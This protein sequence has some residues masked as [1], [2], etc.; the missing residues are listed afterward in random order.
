MIYIGLNDQ[1]HVIL[2]HFRVGEMLGPSRFGVVKAGD[3]WLLKNL[4]MAVSIDYF[5]LP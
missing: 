5:P 3:E 1:R 2:V 4:A